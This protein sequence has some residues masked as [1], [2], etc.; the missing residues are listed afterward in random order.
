MA[1]RKIEN[2][3]DQLRRIINDCGL[4]RYQ[5]SKHTNIAESTLSQF[6]HGERGLSMKA[7]DRLGQF[8]ELTVDSQRKPLK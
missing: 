1:R 2:V 8:L 7:L 5:I 4:S 3:S 6:M